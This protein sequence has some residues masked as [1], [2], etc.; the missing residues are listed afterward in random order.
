MTVPKMQSKLSQPSTESSR[1]KRPLFFGGLAILI[2]L[3]ISTA[4]VSLI[5]LHQQAEARAVIASQ[6][7]AKSLVLT[8]DGLIDTINLALLASSND[9]SR[10]ISTEKPNTQLITLMLKQQKDHIKHI[11]YI[12]A[13]D[14]KGEVIYGPDVIT[15]P[16]S[17]AERD[18]FIH[19]KE[20]PNAGLY[21]S[22]PLKSIFS[23]KW[24]WIF[25][26][27]ITRSDGTFGGVVYAPIPID[28]IHNIF[29]QMNIDNGSSIALRDTEQ[30]LIARYAPSST[31]NFPVGDKKLSEDFIN[32]LKM[33]SLEGTYLSGTT[34]IDGIIRIHSYSRSAK[35]GF[36]INV[37]V[38]SD[39]AF[40]EWRKQ[41]WIVGG[42]VA[43]FILTLLIFS[44]LIIRLWTRREQDMIKLRLHEGELVHIAHFDTLTGVPNRHL[45]ADRLNQAVSYARRHSTYLAV[46]YLD[47]DDFKPINDRYGHV[48]GDELL[49]SI[50]ERLKGAM[51]NEDTL[52]RLGGDEFVML[53]GH[54]P[55]LEEIQVVLDRMLAVVC[56]PS[57]IDGVTL[58]VSASVGVT[59]YPDDDVDP[60][61]LLRHADQAMYQAKEAGK[62]RYQLFDPEHDRQVQTHRTYRHRLGEALANEEFILHYQ[63]KV[64][65][66][67]GEIIGAEALIRWQHPDQ[68]LLFP[69]AFLHYLD[70]RELVIAVGEWVINSALKQ[71]S[72]W[73]TIGLPLT[74]SVNISADHLLQPDF[75]DRLKLSLANHPNVAP[76]CLELEIVETV[77]LSDMKQAVQ[78]LSRC[79][80]LGVQIS[81]DDFGTGY[82]SLTYLRNLPVHTLKIDQSF[83]RDMLVDQNDFSIVESV[84]L[85]AHAFNMAVIAEGVETLEHGAMLVHLG[86]RQMQGYAIARPMPADQMPDW[87]GQWRDKAVWL[88]LEKQPIRPQKIVKC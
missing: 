54:L 13:S 50:A 48:V 15:Q 24:I 32:A 7:L 63:P 41:V 53:F 10:Q 84:V 36:I 19:L 8:F 71:I 70:G 86:C 76:C 33:S 40:A 22:N 62:N 21:I 82:S 37:G 80:E 12:R 3:V 51:R 25:A 88:T 11:V 2:L 23:Q 43:T 59:I 83:V 42:L 6:N 69:G 29:S 47:I 77:A 81:L 5:Q 16:F 66:V 55:H 74:I 46:C 28:A 27:R 72:A 52:A 26:R 64:D 73:D 58:K 87:V 75:V 45:L 79:R 85:M 67:S 1:L 68:G 61:T 14:E 60:D 35:Y 4:L 17:I 78:I 38:L 49:I 9:I 44:K 65:L 30:A 39:S 56:S 57:Q 20:D 34:S 31:T 18:Y